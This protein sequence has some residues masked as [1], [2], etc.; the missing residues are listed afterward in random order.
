M[1][2]LKA[3]P[4]LVLPPKEEIVG[5]HPLSMVAY[6]LL[7]L[8]R[9]AKADGR[10]RFSSGV[11]VL[12]PD[13]RSSRVSVTTRTTCTL[14]GRK[15][16]FPTPHVREL[17]LP[18]SPCC[19]GPGCGVEKVGWTYTIGFATVSRAV[20]GLQNC[21]SPPVVRSFPPKQCPRRYTIGISCDVHI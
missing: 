3:V 8:L 18:F 2:T 17:E 12:V 14:W 7:P 6:R 21:S 19:S 11:R 5:F 20:G 4:R 13:A 15:K 9:S 1:R 16:A 10:G